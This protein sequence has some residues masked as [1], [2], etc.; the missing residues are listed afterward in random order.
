MSRHQLQPT[1]VQQE[2]P[3]EQGGHA[4]FVWNLAVEQ[5]APRRPGPLEGA[6][7][8]CS[9]GSWHR[10]ERN[11]QGCGCPPGRSSCNNQALKDVAQAMAHVFADTHRRPTWR[12]RGPGRRLAPRCDPD[13]QST[14]TVP[15]HGASCGRRK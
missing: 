3:A 15:P 14:P 8:C 1:A 5:H 11:S 10:P 2:A 7:I 13:R 6:R 9:A 12:R 4:R